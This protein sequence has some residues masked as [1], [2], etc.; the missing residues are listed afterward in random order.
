[1]HCIFLLACAGSPAATT[2]ASVRPVAAGGV[3]AHLQSAAMGGYG[4]PI[5]RGAIQIAA[6]IAQAA[7]AAIA[8]EHKLWSQATTIDAGNPNKRSRVRNWRVL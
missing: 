5:V 6:A 4:A 8:G 2:Q 7:G 1:M 3:S